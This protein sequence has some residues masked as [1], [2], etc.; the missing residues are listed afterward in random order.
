MFQQVQH[1]HIEDYNYKL[2]D[3]Y[4]AKFPLDKRDESKLFGL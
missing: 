4:I 2:P 3:N 1:I